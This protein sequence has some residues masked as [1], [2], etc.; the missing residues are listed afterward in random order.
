MGFLTNT[1]FP[2]VRGGGVYLSAGA[3]IAIGKH[4]ARLGTHGDGEFVN[5]RGTGNLCCFFAFYV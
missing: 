4:Y 3:Q 5:S 2:Q 1:I